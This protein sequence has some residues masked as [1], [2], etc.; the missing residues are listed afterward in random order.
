MLKLFNSLTRKKEEFIPIE[1]RMVKMYTCGPTVYNYIHI[2]NFRTFLFED[3]LRRYLKYKGY[4][5]IQVM[6]L[7]D[8]EDKIIRDYQK[9][10]MSLTAFTEVY[11]QA[12]F[13]DIET[14]NIERAEYYPKATEHI[15]EMVELIQRLRE[16][17]YTYEIDGSIYYDISKFP[18]YGK[19]SH[20]DF[21]GLK[22]GGSGRV[23]TDEY[24]KEDVKDFVLWKA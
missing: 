3:L 7:T 18:E 1:E 17:G 5:V 2:G 6:N 8:I 4:R 16:K 24:T 10:G 9:A 20:I 23:D 15:S 11:T 12:F 22:A 13:E 21:S 14:L 19:L